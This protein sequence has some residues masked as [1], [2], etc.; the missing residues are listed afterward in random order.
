MQFRLRT[1]LHIFLSGCVLLVVTYAAVACQIVQFGNQ[2]SESPGDAAVVLGAAAWGNKPSPVYRERIM[3]ALY[4]YKEGRVRWIIFTGGTPKEGYPS[5]AEVAR[6]FA[7]AN[8][9]PA[10]SILVDIHSRSTKQN[11]LRAKELMDGA[12]IQTAL[13]VSDPLHMRR[14]MT[15]ATD[16]NLHAMPSPTVSSRIQ[17]WKTW[18]AFLWR[19]TWLYLGYLLVR[20]LE[21]KSPL[22]LEVEKFS[23]GSV[24][25][26][27]AYRGS[28]RLGTAT[29]ACMRHWAG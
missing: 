14:A 12:G 21:Y 6:Q 24:S 8:D 25:S 11:L 28:G 10:G 7:I 20:T 2:K 16:I 29:S 13:L 5:E 4:L 1:L 27:E 9:I 26:L 15:I 3:E 23:H 17:T 19:E 18:G 22:D